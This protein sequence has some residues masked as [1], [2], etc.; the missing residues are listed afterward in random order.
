MNGG[1]AARAV[2]K[3]APV[4]RG[5]ILEAAAIEFSETGLAG[6]SLQAI[7]ARAD[8][9]HPRIVQ[10]FG[11][12]QA[13]FLEV[14]D[15]V[16]DR[17]VAAFTD[18]TDVAHPSPGRASL[19]IL[20]DAYRRLLQRDRTVPLVMLHG[21]AAA[22]ELAVRAAVARRYLGLQ[23]TVTELTGADTSQV[24]TLFAT[25]LV[26][27]VSTALALPGKRA[28]SRWAAQMLERVS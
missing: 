21:F 19:T 1:A 14:V 25:G 27:T 5:E 6:T 7:A 13:L 3:P 11:S 8:I 26:A 12:K 22:S 9:S 16:F 17:V 15:M 4:R 20:G 23:Q 10:M 28:D 18:A 24:R 2:R